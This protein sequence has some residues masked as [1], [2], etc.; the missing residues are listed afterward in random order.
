M[1]SRRADELR[2]GEEFAPL[3]FHVSEEMNE[4]FLH[5]VEDLHPRYM[6]GTADGPA[7]VHPALLINF[8]NN[9]RSPSFYLPAGMAAIHTHEDVEHSGPARVGK[10]FRVLWKVTGRY[11]RRGREYQVVEAPIVDEDGDV[12]A[13]AADH[14][15]VHGRAAP[16]GGRTERSSGGA[17]GMERFTQ[18]AAVGYEVA[19][20]PKKMTSYRTWLFSGGWPRFDG[21]P[22]KNVHTDLASAQQSGLPTR[23]ASGAMMQGY[24]CE[25]MI[26]L[27]GER[28][29]WGGGD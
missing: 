4:N 17:G 22:A 1:G 10:R 13:H 12:G 28:A 7:L 3:E 19:G 6:E 18:D 14:V 29:G 8:S 26:D 2:V 20:P 5:A 16:R 24:L 15:H 25:L 9:T 11:E 21:W 23:A 27:F